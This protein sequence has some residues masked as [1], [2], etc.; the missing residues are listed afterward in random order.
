MYE[1]WVVS[2]ASGEWERYTVKPFHSRVAARDWVRTYIP[3]AK[4]EIRP[5]GTK[6]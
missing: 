6:G 5:V 3:T 2:D 4:A 1:V